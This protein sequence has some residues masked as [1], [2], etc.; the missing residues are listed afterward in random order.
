MIREVGRND[1]GDQWYISGW[2]HGPAKR[3]SPIAASYTG[4]PHWLVVGA[5]TF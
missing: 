5:F 4:P 3:G 2:S 1:T